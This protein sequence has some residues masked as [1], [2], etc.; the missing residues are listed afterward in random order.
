VLAGLASAAGCYHGASEDH[1]I[2]AEGETQPSNATDGADSGADSGDDDQDDVADGGRSD[3]GGDS[4]AGT[5]GSDSGPVNDG[6]TT[7]DSGDGQG[8]DAGSGGDSSG[9]EDTD[10]TP[11]DPFGD[12]RQDCVDRINAFRATEGLPPYERW[13][14]AESCSDDQAGLDADA[15][16]HGNFGMCDESAQNTCPGWPSLSAVLD[17]CLQLMWDEGPGEPFSA[18]G[19]YINMSSTQYSKVACGFHT[20]QNGEIW[21]SQNFK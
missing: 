10:T 3:D 14:S 11:D 17:G 6:T 8:A 18:H 1:E 4:P 9:S 15:G 19:H 2:A 12:A 5:D 7:S 13:A 21:A 16:P 20:M